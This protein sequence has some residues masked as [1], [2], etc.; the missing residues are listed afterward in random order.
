MGLALALCFIGG[1]GRRPSR[2]DWGGAIASFGIA[3]YLVYRHAT[4]APLPLALIA[5]LGVTLVWTAVGSRAW[6]MRWFDWIA[7]A[8]SLVICLYIT[9]RYEPLTYEIALLPPEGIIGSAILVLLV[10]EATRRT[11]GCN[12]GRHHPDPDRLRLHRSPSSRRLSTRPVTPERLLVYF[13]LDVNGMIGPLLGVA[14]LIVV[15]FTLMGQVLGRTGGAAFFADIAMSGWDIS[16]AAPPRS[17]SWAR[18]CSA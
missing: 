6:A 18:R 5:C 2:F 15:P 13:G 11:A 14:V 7:A 17:R 10:L 9:V 1:G 4:S 16:A 12:A 8:L 3:A